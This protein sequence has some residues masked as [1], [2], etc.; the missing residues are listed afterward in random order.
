M[1]VRIIAAS[2]AVAGARCEFPP[3]LT[4]IIQGEST[5]RKIFPLA[6]NLRSAERREEVDALLLADEN[7]D[8]L[9][10]HE[11]QR[12]GTSKTGDQMGGTGEKFEE[13]CFEDRCVEERGRGK[14]EGE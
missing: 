1:I 2:P 10:R 11:V 12:R 9:H 13:R 14:V 7:R 8:A 6:E 5:R 4:V 3:T